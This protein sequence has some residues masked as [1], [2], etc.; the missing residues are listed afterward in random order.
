ME[1][2]IYLFICS[3]VIC[4]PAPQG[5]GF[6]SSVLGHEAVH[7]QLAFERRDVEPPHALEL[8]QL[9][10]RVRRNY[11]KCQCTRFW[12]SIA[13]ATKIKKYEIIIF[14]IQ[15]THGFLVLYKWPEDCVYINY[16]TFWNCA[17]VI[18]LR[19]EVIKKLLSIWSRSI[20]EFKMD[21]KL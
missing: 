1:K 10:R 2:T 4:F 14:N 5:G 8:R 16:L 19:P 17:N 6:D 9:V 18:P 11:G 20:F 12:A 3:T 15:W 13:S 7:R 21:N